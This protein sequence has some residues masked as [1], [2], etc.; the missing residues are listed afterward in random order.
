MSLQ[1]ITQEFRAQ[2]PDDSVLAKA[3]DENQPWMVIAAIAEAEGYPLFAEALEAEMS[4]SSPGI[5]KK[6]GPIY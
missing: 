1:L 5:D 2:L 4:G 6:P 3:I